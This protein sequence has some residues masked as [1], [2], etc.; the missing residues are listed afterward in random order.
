MDWSG[1]PLS[2]Y[3][4]RMSEAPENGLDRTLEED[5]RASTASTVE[6]GSERRAAGANSAAPALQAGLTGR[7]ELAELAL[8]LPVVSRAN[9]EFI[10]EI[11]RGG[12]GRISLARDLRLDRVVAI[13]ELLRPTFSNRARFLREIELTVRL[14]HPNIVS[15]HEA[16]RWPDG[17]PFYAMNHVAGSTLLQRIEAAQTREERLG[18]LSLVV[19]VAEAIALAHSQGI[20]HRDLKPANVLVGPFGETVVIDWGLA[21]STAAPDTLRGQS[22]GAEIG[23]TRAG[24]IVGSPP[25]MPPE[26]ARGEEVDP[27]AD[28]YALGALLY[29][30]LSGKPPFFETPSE[31]LL[32]YMR[33]RSPVPLREVAPQLPLD[34]IAI[35]DKALSFNAADRYDDGGQMALELHRFTMGRLVG[36]YEYRTVDLLRRFVHRNLAA[37]VTACVAVLCLLGVGWLS[38]ERIRHERDLAQSNALAA[39]RERDLARRQANS[40]LVTR[41]RAL[42]RT[43]PTQALAWLK[44]L[45]TVPSGAVSVALQ[46]YELG[47]ARWV[48]DHHR[49]AINCIAVHPRGSHLASGSDDHRVTVWSFDEERATSLLQHEDRVATCSYSPDGRWLASAGWDGQVLLWDAQTY[50]P[51]RLPPPGGA[52]KRL[53]FSHNSQQLAVADDQGVIRRYDLVRNTFGDVRAPPERWPQLIWSDSGLFSGPHLGQFWFMPADEPMWRSPVTNATTAALISGPRVLLGL[54]SGEIVEWRPN[55]P[56]GQPLAQL[57]APITSLVQAATVPA[58]FFAATSNG[59]VYAIAGSS[60]SQKP[61]PVLRH[62]ER[63]AALSTSADGRFVASGGWDKRVRVYDTRTRSITTLYGHDDVVSALQ[64][65]PDGRYLISASWDQ[66]VRIW[67]LQDALKRERLVLRGHDVGVHSV[68]FSHDG[69]YIASGGHDHTVRLWRL[70]GGL[71]RRFTGHTDIVYRVIFS[72]DDRWLASSSDDQTVRLFRTDGSEVRVLEGHLADVEE[73]AFSQDGKWLASASED[74]TAR[75]WNMNDGRIHVLRHRHDVTR[76]AFTPDS[77]HLATSSRDG[78]VRVFSVSDGQLR[79]RLEQPGPAWWVDYSADGRV[80]ATAGDGGVFLYSRAGAQQRRLPVSKARRAVFA[81]NGKYIAVLGDAQG[82]WLCE[83]DSASCEELSDHQSVVRAATF[84]PDSSSLV[85]AGGEGRVY[86]WDVATRE[87]RPYDGHEA[88]VFDVDIAP[89]GSSI[90][91]ASGDKTVRLWP[92]LSLPAPR[93]LPQLLDAW[94]RQ[95]VAEDDARRFVRPHPTSASSHEPPLE[96]PQLNAPHSTPAVYR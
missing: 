2:S 53:Q 10:E 40:L 5:D 93:E 57:D 29:H 16:G 95:T 26:Q 7:A 28:V 39:T 36:A 79:Q 88:P 70:D 24:L 37:I 60:P 59:D 20:V 87:S 82:F 50:Q 45:E 25:Y 15:L 9:Y 3:D 83:I 85:S 41:A 78:M 69:R 65:T 6:A 22:T 13:K 27:R 62:A 1:D 91:T 38:I 66:T 23:V 68:R 86:L 18:L 52:I 74:G 11:A 90:A 51:R 49:G 75:L 44:Q 14:Q 21:K 92:R 63:T 17:Q 35:V 30:A 19:Q 4:R 94:T 42:T 73:L 8:K 72:P 81:P 34:L 96:A 54:A 55:L 31:Q 32:E 64:F 58:T 61:H 43:K 76:V 56:L 67:S 47:I 46:A 84:S 77:K 89:N 80:L 33:H 71:E 48:L 12:L